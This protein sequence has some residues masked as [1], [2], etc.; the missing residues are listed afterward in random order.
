M[1]FIKIL[2]CKEKRKEKKRGGSEKRV[3]RDNR[4]KD[5]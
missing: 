2:L 3:E 5:I 4:E 1:V